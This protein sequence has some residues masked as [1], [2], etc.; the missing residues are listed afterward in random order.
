MNIREGVRDFRG[1]S[2]PGPVG[3]GLE[4]SCLVRGGY[5]NLFMSGHW[6]QFQ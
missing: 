5:N 4:F 1:P 6:G 3:G 2:I